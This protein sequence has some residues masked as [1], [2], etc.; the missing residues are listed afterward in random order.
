MK[1]I[2]RNMKVGRDKILGFLIVLLIISALV[3]IV[4]VGSKPPLEPSP[5]DRT[6]LVSFNS[7]GTHGG[8]EDSGDG[9]RPIAVSDT[10]RYIV[11]VSKAS[12]LDP[13][14]IDNERSLD[15]F[16]RDR[17][18]G[19]T[20]CVSRVGDEAFGKYFEGEGS[21]NS[22]VDISGDGRYVTFSGARFDDHWYRTREVYVYDCDDPN[23]YT[24]LHWITENLPDRWCNMHINTLTYPSISADGKRI[25]YQINFAG[26]PARVPIIFLCIVLDYDT[27][28]YTHV[29]VSEAET[30]VCENSYGQYPRISGDGRYVLFLSDP[31][32]MFDSGYYDY[33]YSLVFIRN[34]NTWDGCEI[35]SLP[36]GICWEP[37][38]PDIEDLPNDHCGAYWDGFSMVN[39]QYDL[40]NNGRFIVFGTEADD[41]GENDNNNRCDVYIRDRYTSQTKRVSW[42]YDGTEPIWYCNRPS[43]S[44]NGRYVSFLTK[45]EMIIPNDTN[46]CTDVFLRDMRQSK[47][48]RI[49]VPD[50]EMNDEEADFRSNYAV[51]STSNWVIAFVSQANNLVQEETPAS[52]DVYVRT[53]ATQP[54][55]P[56][57]VEYI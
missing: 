40:S 29:L 23:S 57:F 3:F 39:D 34:I 5:S 54:V 38:H 21:V 41:L 56:D 7:G 45:D 11:F 13:Y 24:A 49:S 53:R 48:T 47:N 55:H 37:E 50:D 22:A 12:D 27:N 10:G 31:W 52:Y 51:I 14:I 32:C 26:P 1:K 15:I 46:G 28:T 2:K 20:I 16:R 4:P 9:F 35:V 30:Y 36:D 17:F 25:A 19:E 18:T 43:I 44:G 8:D 33:P 6:E 42:R